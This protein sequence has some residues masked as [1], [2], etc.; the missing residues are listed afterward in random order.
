MIN[1][2]R[3]IRTAAAVSVLAF[4]TSI[5]AEEYEDVSFTLNNGTGL[6]IVEFYASPPNEE[7][8]EEDILGVDVLEDGDSV[9]IT[10]G[11]SRPDCDYDFK[12]VFEDGTDLV[13]ESISVCGGEEYTYQ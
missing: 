11:D 7:E 10:L 6:I 1:M 3:I 12:A 2:M 4:S 9:D 5:W 13:H 8:W